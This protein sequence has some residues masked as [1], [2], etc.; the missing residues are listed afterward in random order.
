[1]SGGVQCLIFDW[2]ESPESA[3]S[4]ASVVGPFDPDHDGDAEFFAIAP[5]LPVQDVLL[6]QREERFHRGVVTARADAAHRPDEVVV[7]ERGDERVGA[8]LAAPVRMHDG[9]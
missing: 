3:L 8:E 1:M 9:P 5:A 2:G 7:L 6:E 4:A